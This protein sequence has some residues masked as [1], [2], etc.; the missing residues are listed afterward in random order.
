[1]TMPKTK[2]SLPQDLEEKLDKLSSLQEEKKQLEKDAIA[3]LK[4]TL[5]QL[6]KDI[7]E[8]EGVRWSQYI[9]GFNDGEPCEFSVN[10][11]EVKFAGISEADCNS[12]ESLTGETDGYG[13]I[14]E[15]IDI[16]QYAVLKEKYGD[17]LFKYLEKV[18]DTIY[19]LEDSLQTAF[20]DNARV[21]VTKDG[22]EVEEYDCGY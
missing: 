3:L 4:G 11:L 12:I 8:L 6:L 13:P 14:A 1:M 17:K 18:N 10:E 7:P 15:Q 21:V 5:Q 16:L 2:L 19:D 9:P 20:G 22:I